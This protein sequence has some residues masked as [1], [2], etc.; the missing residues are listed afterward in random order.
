MRR[1]GLI[2]I[3]LDEGDEL[4]AVDLSDGSH[5]IILGST[6]GMA[7]HFNEKNVRPMG[8]QARGV[9]AMTL[10]HGDTI[11]AMD[12]VERR[13]PRSAAGHVAGVRQAHAR[14]TSTATPRAAAKASKRSRVS[15]TTSAKSSIRFSSPPTT[16][17]S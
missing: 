10:E 3:D 7:V 2:A 14:S 12:V 13:P 9:K 1:N 6:Q 15:A 8:R 5:D 17:Y 16:R 4:L 11:V